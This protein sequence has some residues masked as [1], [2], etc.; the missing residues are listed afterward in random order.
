MGKKSKKQSRHV[1][2]PSSEKTVQTVKL[3]A[4]ANWQ[5]RD[6]FVKAG[7]TVRVDK[8]YADILLQQTRNFILI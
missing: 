6:Q 2:Q 5:L 7:E 4:K 3:K 1:E 8:D